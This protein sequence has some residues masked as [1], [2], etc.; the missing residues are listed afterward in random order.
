APVENF[1]TR[2]VASP[3]LA[4]AAG[5]AAIVVA[6]HASG[7]GQHAG[8]AGLATMRQML[9]LGI[10]APLVFAGPGQLELMAR[11]VDE[12]HVQPARIVGAASAALEAGLRAIAGLAMDV[13]GAE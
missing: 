12:L 13:S 3:D 9:A 8:D 6:D 4:S 1:S 5:A 10:D 2:V 11:C 7:K